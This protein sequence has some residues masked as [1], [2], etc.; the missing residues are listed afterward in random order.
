MSVIAERSHT[1]ENVAQRFVGRD[2]A[3]DIFYQRF[4]YRHIKNAVYYHADGGIGKTWVLQKI[5]LD[6]QNDGLRTVSGII[7]FYDTQNQSVEGLQATI[8]S[9]LDVPKNPEIFAEYDDVLEQLEQVRNDSAAKSIGLLASLE[10]RSNKLFIE[11]CQRAATGREV[12]MLFDTFERVQE[13]Y[14]GNWFLTEFLPQVRSLTVV[15]AGRPTPRP[16]E[17]PDNVVSYEL[18]GLTLTEVQ[19]YVKKTWSL[20]IPLV[21]IERIHSHT[22]GAPLLMDLIF[23]LASNAYIGDLEELDYVSKIEDTSE[24]KNELTKHFRSGTEFDRILW[25]MSFLKRR[26]DLSILQHVVEYSKFLELESYNYIELIET[27]HRYK[28]VKEYPALESHLLHDEMQQ[29]IEEFLLEQVDPRYQIRDDLFKLIVQDYYSNNIA[30]LQINNPILAKQFQA[31]Q[32]GYILDRGVRKRNLDEGLSQYQNYLALIEQN[33][34][35]DFEELLWGELRS[36]LHALAD[37]GYA[38]AT[39][40]GRWLR[41]FTLF[42]KAEAHYHEILERFPDYEIDITKSLGFVLIRLGKVRQAIEILERGRSLSVNDIK[43]IADFENLL[44]LATQA[45]GRWDEALIHFTQGLRAFTLSGNKAGMAGIYINRGFLYSLQGL[46]DDAQQEC[47]LALRLLMQIPQ[48]SLEI[49]RLTMYAE[50]NLGTA[51]RHDHDYTPAELHYKQALEIAER[52]HDQGGI[53]TALQN[54][55]IN[56]C[57]T[58]RKLRRD[59]QDFVGAGRMQLHAWHYL[60]RALAI[61]QETAWKAGLADGF[62]RMAEV[63]EEI[64]RLLSTEAPDSLSTEVEQVLHELTDTTQSFFPASETEYQYELLD[65]RPFS[66][67]GWLERPTRLY[68]L[69]SIIADEINDFHRA[70]DSLMDFARLLLELERYEDVLI[71]VR[72][73]ERIKGFDYQADLFS[74]MADITLADLAFSQGRYDEALNRYAHTFA[75]VAQQTGYATYLLTDRLRGLDHHIRSL[76]ITLRLQWCDFLEQHWLESSVSSIRPD[77]LRLLETIRFETISQ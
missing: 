30:D 72:R 68:E 47:N 12:V 41:K 53:S 22:R 25:A 69:S 62:S 2:E 32:F 58:G 1:S 28:F 33:H 5:L 59:A 74:V 57:L 50:L 77:M 23:D 7:D 67:L 24:L 8:R 3:L 76:P 64:C 35:Y 71:A 13:R 18:H 65:N 39:E 70:L 20:D 43:E 9:H 51:F 54:L 49:Q 31:E 66:Q 55:G 61:A 27:L 36:H 48:Q 38:V 37:G 26:F 75:E 11:A 46:S 19:A 15:F 40:R 21:I 4:A 52:L 73:V 10:N 45:A 6:N 34:D 14:V 16:A 44:G 29:I 56:S 63:Y 60:V 42:A 17:V